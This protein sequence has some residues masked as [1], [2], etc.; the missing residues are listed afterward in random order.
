MPKKEIWLGSCRVPPT[1]AESAETT[2]PK[3]FEPIVV[4]RSRV[5]D[6]RVSFPCVVV[7]AFSEREKSD[8]GSRR[9]TSKTYLIL[10]TSSNRCHASSNRCL[11]SSN[12]KLLELK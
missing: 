3:T 7:A 5:A 12:K 10:F 11:T 4:R 1:C 9:F 8:L 6:E 2:V